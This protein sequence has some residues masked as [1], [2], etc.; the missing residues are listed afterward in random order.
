MSKTAG[1]RQDVVTRLHQVLLERMALQPWQRITVR[2]LAADAGIARQTFYQYFAGRDALLVDY[3]DGMF[4][5]FYEEIADLI[6]EAPV[7]GEDISR[8]LFAQWQRHRAFAERVFQAGSES[9]LINRFRSYIARVLGLYVREHGIAVT[10]T[11]QLGFMI[12][13]LAGASWMVLARWVKDGFAYPQD[14]L[15]QLFSQLTRPGFL[16]V[17]DNSSGSAVSP[18]DICR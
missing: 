18:A 9:L 5:V 11:E 13:Y 2:E 8:H 3:V 4:A 17:L 7:P 16:Q 6:R 12:D 15:A 14:G 10:D 1:H